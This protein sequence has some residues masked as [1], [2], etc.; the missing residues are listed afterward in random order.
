MSIHTYTRNKV[1][2]GWDLNVDTLGREAAAAL[3]G[4]DFKLG[5]KDTVVEFS[6]VDTLTAPEV[7]RLDQVVADNRAAGPYPGTTK[8]IR[9]PLVQSPDG[10]VFEILVDNSGVL[11]TS[12]VA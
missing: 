11:S 5:A 2:D 6:F 8:T 12:K 1:G 3:P 7:A 9:G 4:K 10:S